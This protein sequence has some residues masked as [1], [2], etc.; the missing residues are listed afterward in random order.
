MTIWND[1]ELPSHDP[2]LAALQLK[3]LR[4]HRMTDIL[5][6]YRSDTGQYELSQ[7]DRHPTA[8]A[9]QLIARYVVEH[10]LEAG[11]VSPE[12]EATIFWGQSK[13]FP[14]DCA[15]SSFRANGLG[16][17]AKRWTPQ[18]QTQP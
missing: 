16:H 15:W 4:L 2:V 3:G 12:H 8:R 11:A 17:P 14:Q 9:Y 18:A 10:I 6:G 5:P 1:K 13:N 7:F